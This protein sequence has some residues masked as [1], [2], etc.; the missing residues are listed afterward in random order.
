[1]SQSWSQKRGYDQSITSKWS[2]TKTANSHTEF[3]TWTQTDGNEGKKMHKAP[4]QDNNLMWFC[5]C[6]VSLNGPDSALPEGCWQEKDI[7]TRNCFLIIFYSFLNKRIMQDWFFYL[8]EISS[9]EDTSSLNDLWEL[10]KIDSFINIFCKKGPMF[11]HICFWMEFILIFPI[12]IHAFINFM[13]MYP[14][15][16]LLLG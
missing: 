12:T 4:K 1:M 14:N 10:C 3:K 11:I 9:V 5:R 13:C 2:V 7:D 15:H 8:H 6:Y 16:F